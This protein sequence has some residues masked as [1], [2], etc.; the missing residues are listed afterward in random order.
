MADQIKMNSDAVR[1]AAAKFATEADNIR[2]M[3]DR[4]NGYK[5]T[6][7]GNWSGTTKE[8]FMQELDVDTVTKISKYADNFDKINKAL[9]EITQAFEDTDG[10]IAG[11]MQID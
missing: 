2:E 9:I 6:L 10:E 7:N 11:K 5:N 1:D 4:I 8:K 3:V